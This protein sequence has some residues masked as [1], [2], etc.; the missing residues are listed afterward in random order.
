MQPRKGSVNQGCST[1]KGVEKRSRRK[2]KIHAKSIQK[3]K[4]GEKSWKTKNKGKAKTK[5]QGTRA[6]R[7]NPERRGQRTEKKPIQ[8]LEKRKKRLYITGK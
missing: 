7:E 6:L 4:T 3:Q 2:G 5:G 8:L 1:L